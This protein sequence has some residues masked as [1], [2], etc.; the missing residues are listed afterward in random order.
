MTIRTLRRKPGHRRT[1]R[2]EARADVVHAASPR[3][4]TLS[5]GAVAARAERQVLLAERERKEQ[6]SVLRGLLWV[7]LLALAVSMVRAGLHRTF[8]PGWWRQW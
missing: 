1:S 2:R 8:Y 5:K 7:A 4:P 3:P 6:R